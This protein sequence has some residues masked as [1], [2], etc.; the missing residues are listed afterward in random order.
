MIERITRQQSDTIIFGFDSAGTD[1]PKSPGAICAIAFD[2]EGKVTF[3]LPELVSFSK[4]LS[5]ICE[6]KQGFSLCLAA[7]DQPT[8]VANT[9]GCRPV[10][11][12]AASVVSFAG[13]GV[14][15]ANTDKR[16]MFDESAPIWRFKNALKA[17]DSFEESRRSRSGTFLIEVF[18]ALALAGLNDQF[19][20]RLGAPKYNP[21]NRSK[22]R[23]S[24][25]QA[26]A[27]TVCA[28][29]A[30]LQLPN[31]ADWASEQNRIQ[32]PV[33]RNQD[34]LYAAVCALV[35][36]IWRGCDPAESVVIGDTKSGFIITPVSIETRT[37]L[38]SAAQSCAVPI[39]SGD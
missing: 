18:P 14:Q 34:C 28:V 37:R 17:S 21:K 33:K 16:G 38:K 25:W 15:P 39:N 6:K 31:L 20:K 27:Q 12:V 24:D 26:V 8:I 3:A 32:S 1:G 7:L 23:I 9:K 2:R 11:R 10:D 19:S 22:F 35:G 30:N 5:I 13:E 29:A 4:A 36:L